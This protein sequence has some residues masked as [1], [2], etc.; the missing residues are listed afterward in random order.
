[1]SDLSNLMK[2]SSPEPRRSLGS[3]LS[4]DW[5]NSEAGQE[6]LIL[7][8]P[9]VRAVFDAKTGAWIDYEHKPTGWKIQQRVE[10]GQSFRAYAAWKDRLFNPVSGL[11]CQLRHATL[12]DSAQQITFDWDKLRTSGGLELPVT[13]R[14]Q[15][16][17]EQGRLTFSG[18]LENG[19]DATITTLSWPVLGDL[20]PPHPTDSL[21]RENLDYGTMKRTPLWPQTGNERGYY[22]TNY[23]MQIEG[24]GS[25]LSGIPGAY[26]FPQRFVLL[27]APG[28][29]IYIGSHDTSAHQM[30]CFQSELRPGYLDS[31][32][33]FSPDLSKLGETPVHL[34]IEAVHYPMAAP[35]ETIE[36]PN[37]V[38]E[39]YLGD[40]HGGLDIYRR[41]RATWYQQAASPDWLHDVHS[42]QQIQIGS[43]EG[44][45]RTAFT[46]LP[47]R[48]RQLA[49]H[50]VTALQLVGWN[51]GGQ[52]RGNPS[53]DPDQRLGTWE[54]LK[55]AIA[56][57]EALGVR[58][59]L[60]NKFVWADVTRAD[61]ASF[62][63]SAAVDPYGMPYYHP[64][65]EYQTPV[66]WM[67]IN[68]R[69]FMVACLHDP[70]WISLCQRE[71]EK[72]LSLGAS[73]ILYDEAFHHYAATHC[74]SEKHGH[75]APATLASGDLTLGQTFQELLRQRNHSDF[76][77]SA[78]A[79]FDLQ[80][81][82]YALSYFRIFQGHI[83][84]ERY[85]DPFYPIMIAVTGFDDREMI[86]RALLYRYIISYEPYNFKGDL[87]DFPLTMDYGKKVDAFRSRYS[88]YLWKGE[89][90]DSLGAKVDTVPGAPISYSVF[91]DAK[92]KLR[93][94]VL[95]NDDRNAAHE[96][97]LALDR[98]ASL[99]FA[100]PESLELQP[101]GPQVTVPA[102]SAL[103]VF[104]D[105]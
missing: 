67:S 74:F 51:Q 102:R 1:M 91:L 54:D 46:D 58:V 87:D 14:A 2:N 4:E 45:L 103:V 34:T 48:A 97:T 52:D 89:F 6:R 56:K 60:F 19:S 44:D 7:E 64:G 36:L 59:I 11:S 37:I 21:F 15:V 82:H 94:V 31:F 105:R 90:R 70:A 95:I 25:L 79:P 81:Q 41:W 71:F 72:S 83:P 98:A 29:G 80:H 5:W 96:A 78:E 104:E 23:P 13:L 20:V 18:R 101:C 33:A 47:T 40:W 28:Q 16:R 3:P 93:A 84:A 55:E 8:D 85:A 66:Q 30:V 100:S 57:I 42:W 24:K 27:S 22:G 75:R 10:L 38:V 53:H 35:G 17:L 88:E 62:L 68:N 39:P 77:L 61:Y 63:D 26:H 76:L 32:H 49:D 12:D 99:S 9:T 73:G 86:N 43:T 65:Y 92:G 69:R 50:G